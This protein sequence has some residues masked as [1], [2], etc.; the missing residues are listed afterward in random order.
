M[1]YPG[2]FEKVLKQI[3]A[4]VT[5]NNLDILAMWEH[6]EG[7]TAAYNP[8]NTTKKA[9]GATQYG[10]NV[11]GVKNYPDFETGV[12]ATADTLKLK[13]YT[14]IVSALQN[15]KALSYWYGHQGIINNLTTWG[16]IG[17]AKQLQNAQQITDTSKKKVIPAAL[18][19]AG[20]AIMITNYE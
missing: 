3:G 18:I 11:A 17:L 16:T 7:G 6:Y 10:H 5:K 13:Y 15:N 8:L 14:D 1:R 20:L 2:F 4:P 9:P 19:I 12:K